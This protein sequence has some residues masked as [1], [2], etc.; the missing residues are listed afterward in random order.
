MYRMSGDNMICGI[1][2][3]EMKQN[4]RGWYCA[5]P[6]E[7]SA[8]GKTVLKWCD[9]K[10]AEEAAVGQKRVEVAEEVREP[11]TDWG[12]IK[13][14]ESMSMVKMSALKAASQ[15][16]SAELSRPDAEVPADLFQYT[17][18]F[19]NKLLKWLTTPILSEG[20]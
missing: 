1:H 4:A 14:K 19:A 13:D 16:I 9:F 12:S 2:N 15:I 8:N 17:E 5:T 7:K 18:T 6:I 3:K 10:P 11:V 20:G